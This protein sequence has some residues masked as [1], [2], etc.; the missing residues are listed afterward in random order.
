MVWSWGSSKIRKETSRRPRQ[1]RAS[2]LQSVTQG[3]HTY[4]SARSR[5][6]LLNGIMTLQ[7]GRGSREPISTSD[8]QIG[9]IDVP[10]AA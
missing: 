10:K 4:S 1:D 3:I 9:D 8:Q 5:K 7:R 2:H 6:I